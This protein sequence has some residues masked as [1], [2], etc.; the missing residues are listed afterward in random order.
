MVAISAFDFDTPVLVLHEIRR[1][2]GAMA[3]YGVNKGD[4]FWVL[5]G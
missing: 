3:I 1:T 2:V 4:D 5:H